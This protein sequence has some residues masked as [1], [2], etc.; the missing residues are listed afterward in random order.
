[1]AFLLSPSAYLNGVPELAIMR[2]PRH[3]SLGTVR[4]YIR[5][6][7]LFRDAGGDSAAAA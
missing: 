5:D 1:M 3:K 6:H 7:S 2:R 4:K